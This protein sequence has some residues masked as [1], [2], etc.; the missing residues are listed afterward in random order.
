MF[1]GLSKAVLTLL[2]KPPG[3]VDGRE[4]AL[5]PDEALRLFS[6]R[7]PDALKPMIGGRVLD[8][9]CGGGALS[10][11]LA[12]AGCS[13]VGLDIQERLLE[14]G[15]TAPGGDLVQFTRHVPSAPVDWVVSIDSMEH[16]SDPLGVLSQMREI[17]APGGR[18]L[19]SFCPTWMAPY[20]AHMH[21]FTKVPWVQYVFPEAA[22]MA[23]RSR[24]VRDGATR[25]EEVEGGLNKMTV[26]RFRELLALAGLRPESMRIDYVKGQ[27]WASRIPLVR[28]LLANQ[29]TSTL[30]RQDVGR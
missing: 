5:D 9:G 25:Y 18:I 26:G 4:D 20:G 29:V 13:V 11:A 28:E 6:E 21:F 24:Y 22:V 27:V 1:T 7:W 12:R 14:V 30:A 17:L 23:V 19:M 2:S 15:R 16:F 8:F 10:I 3:S